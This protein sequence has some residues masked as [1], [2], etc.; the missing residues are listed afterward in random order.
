VVK[1]IAPG[2]RDSYDATP[3]YLNNVGKKS[4]ELDLKSGGAS[5]PRKSWRR[6]PTS[7]RAQTRSCAWSSPVTSGSS[8]FRLCSVARIAVGAH[9][10]EPLVDNSA[11]T[12]NAY[13][14]ADVRQDYGLPGR[15]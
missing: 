8:L 5:P 10:A 14:T 12:G 2:S 6:R 11:S 3:F 7:S 4:I 13:P 9:A 1:V 15:Q